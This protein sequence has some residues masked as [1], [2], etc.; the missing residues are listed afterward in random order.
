MLPICALINYCNQ[1]EEYLK[2]LYL[3]KQ[4]TISSKK[5]LLF[6]DRDK[7]KHEYILYRLYTVDCEPDMNTIGTW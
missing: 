5:K 7:I 4:H 2:S 1:S 3:F 6:G